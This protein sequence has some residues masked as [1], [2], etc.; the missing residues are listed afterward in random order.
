MGKSLVNWLILAWKLVKHQS[1]FDPMW[2]FRQWLMDYWVCLN[3]GVH[4]DILGKTYTTSWPILGGPRLWDPSFYMPKVQKM[5]GT[6]DGFSRFETFIF[7]LPHVIPEGEP[8]NVTTCH[9]SI[10]GVFPFAPP[11][12]M[13]W[14][15]SN[16]RIAFGKWW[17]LEQGYRNWASIHGFQSSELFYIMF[18]KAVILWLSEFLWKSF[19][20]IVENSM[21][22]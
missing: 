7:R 14:W 20:M 8:K 10:S 4:L 21:I 6:T 15:T 13:G 16:C 11:K 2:G 1:F 12:K 3:M 22:K 5:H 17:D 9:N 18:D 19:G